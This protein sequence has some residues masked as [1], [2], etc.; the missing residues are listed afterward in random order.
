MYWNY[1][2]IPWIGN[3]VAHLPF[4]D[5][6]SADSQYWSAGLAGSLLA[7]EQGFSSY[8]YPNEANPYPY[9]L[10]HRERRNRM[11]LL[12]AVE[13]ITSTNSTSSSS[14]TAIATSSQAAK[15]MFQ[16]R[17]DFLGTSDLVPL[18]GAFA[19]R[20]TDF[21]DG[22]GAMDAW[23]ETSKEG[24]VADLDGNG[25]PDWAELLGLTTKDAY[26]RAL[27]RGLLPSATSKDDFTAAYA[28]L[29][30][31][32][33]D[34]VPD[35]W[36]KLYGL[37]GSAQEDTDKDGLADFAEYL[38]S[39]VFDFDGT[40][41]I[42]PTLPMSN[43]K[44]FDYFRKPVLST[45][46]SKVYLG[47]M[48][49][50]HDFMEDHLEREWS[51]IGAD[52]GTY[53]AHLDANENG[54]SNWAEIRAK[55]NMGYEVAA[56]GVKTNVVYQSYVCYEE[57]KNQLALVMADGNGYELLETDFDII[58]YGHWLSKTLTSDGFSYTQHAW[59]DD[60]YGNGYIK[61]RVFAPVYSKRYAYKGHPVPTVSMTVRYNGVRDLTDASLT[62]EAYT[63]SELKRPDATFSVSYGKNRNVN[64]QTLK[65]PA[66]GYLREGKTTFV[67]YAGAASNVTASAGSIMGVVRNVDVGWSG[68][69]FEVE[70]TEASPICPRPSL[71]AAL[72]TTSSSS[73]SSEPDTG[74]TSSH[75]YVY[76][77]AVDEYNPPS[78]L[79][80][81]PVFD[82]E[83]GNRTSLHEGDFL[84]DADFDLDWRN[85]Q[86]DVMGN[87]AVR[88][89]LFPVTSV[90]Y[91]VY[92]KPVDISYEA[93]NPSNGTPY[94]AFSREFG[95]ARAAAVPVAPGEDSTIVYG[96]RPTF[97]WS[98][99]GNR[100]DT[101]TAFAIQVKSGSTVVWSSGVQPAPA[102][103]MNGDY[104]WTAPL[105]PNDQTALGKV[106]AN[107]NNYTWS[108]T[109]YNSKF[110]DNAWSAERMFRV[111]VYADDEVN[112]AGYYGLKAAVKYFGPGAVNTSEA[113][114][115][116]TLRVEAYT[117]PDFSGEPAGRTF[118]RN[119]A[120]L[121]NAEHKVNATI[122]GLKAG[123]YYVRAFI[124]SD[125]DFKRSNWESWGYACPRGDT[126]TGAIYAPT[127]VTIGEGVDTPVARVYVEDADV[128]QDCLPDVWEYDTA[129]TS[130]TDFLLKKGPMANKYNSYIAVNPDLANA[131]SDLINGSGGST[132][133]LLAAAPGQI[134]SGVAALMLGVSTTDPEIQEE[135]LTISGL[136]LDGDNVTFTVSAAADDPLAG[137]KV[138]VSEG[139]ITVTVVVKYADSLDGEWSEKSEVKTFEITDGAVSET[140]TFTLSDLGLDS[141]KG[142]FKVELKQ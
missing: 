27:A 33:F 86:T 74:A 76:R 98:L 4:M 6:S 102:R 42:S 56:N 95:T 91:R 5:G 60:F 96:A 108:V 123:T 103:N 99:A 29:V 9:F 87:I 8:D 26:L 118:I 100:P 84:S 90:T 61:Y 92:F 63:D 37:S 36:Q 78:S 35:W 58:G 68:A 39:E 14:G 2:V 11:D 22:Q 49:S 15:W 72:G 28:S 110:R 18:G 135:T 80:Y 125:G 139:Q 45:G 113:T 1:A 69:S 111:N 30:D 112:N 23:T 122:V 140:F 65:Y 50:D 21:W 31:V 3:T 71:A 119:F 54:W 93:N 106:F 114:V 97:T 116:G 85:F 133:R 34:G 73:G 101:Y 127:A 83:I 115:A 46:V 64:T 17:S 142:F 38:I 13:N 48:F 132:L 16:L 59:H 82:K 134:P 126:E 136:T 77:Y 109:M 41:N 129:G 20:G 66:D 130:K 81:G 128:D 104:Q 131:I 141:S 19:K 47:E 94:L 25:I 70:L 79:N 55:Y 124:D 57:Y 44:E 24:E 62:V 51:E 107:T 120:S 75:I 138:F 53:D 10:Y 137:S 32:N 40:D 89:G 121:T 67:V 43:G 12:S 88:E 7:M 105:Y 52:P 117:T